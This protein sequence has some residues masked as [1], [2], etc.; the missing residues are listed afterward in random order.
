[1]NYCT[2]PT[3]SANCIVNLWTFS[4]IISP[5]DSWKEQEYLEEGEHVRLLLST[6]QFPVENGHIFMILKPLFTISLWILF[7][8]NTYAAAVVC[9]EPRKQVDSIFS[10]Y[11]RYIPKRI[12]N[13]WTLKQHTNY[14][15]FSLIILGQEDS[16]A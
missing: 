4:M 2:F 1:M 12:W 8:F 15:L 3:Y 11:P 9:T 10:V 14:F 7:I 16:Y 13:S 6:V 5:S